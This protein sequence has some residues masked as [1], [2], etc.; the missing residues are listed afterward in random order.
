MPMSRTR[1]TVTV[2]VSTL[3]YLVLAVIGAGGPAAFFAHPPLIVLTIMLLVMAAVTAWS[4][5]H[6]AELDQPM[7]AEPEQAV[8]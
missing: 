3:G 1:L 6:D 5:V 7:E 8:A 2:M 4:L